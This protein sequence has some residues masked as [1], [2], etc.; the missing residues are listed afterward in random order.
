[1]SGSNCITELPDRSMG[2]CH[3]LAAQRDLP[4]DDGLQSLERVSWRDA[5]KHSHR[6]YAGG[7]ELGRLAD[8]VF[9][10]VEP[11]VDDEA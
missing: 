2:A 9:A 7:T 1:M 10:D 4:A 3:L 5:S 8:G 11:F 6:N